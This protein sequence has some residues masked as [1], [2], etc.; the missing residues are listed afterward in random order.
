MFDILIV[1]DD[2][3]LRKLLTAVL[4]R[5]RYTVFAVENG[6]K[7]LELME[8]THIDL[9]ICDIMLP[10]M[11]G[12]E[13]THEIREVNKEI[14]ILTVT[15]RETLEDKRRS[16]EVGTDD[17]MVKPINVE[18]LI[19]RINALLRRARVTSDRRITVGD[20]EINMDSMMLTKGQIQIQIP[21]KEFFI[22][23]K[24]LSMPNHIFTR[25]AIMDEI[26]GPDIETDERTVDVHIK[27]LRERLEDAGVNEFEITT[28]RGLGYKVRKLL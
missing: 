13:L 28:V 4:R 20:V 21:K 2:L 23:F 27:R 16:F 8:N 3:N 9:V 6:E 14:P 25:R 5:N 10:G 26:W 12:Y 17:Y 18:E 7:A 11:N 22:L 24:L 15:A 19:M 1:E